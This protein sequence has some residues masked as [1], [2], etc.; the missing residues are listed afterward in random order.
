[1]EIIV[2]ILC[3]LLLCALV[4]GTLQLLSKCCK[5]Q[6]PKWLRWNK[7]RTWLTVISFVIILGRW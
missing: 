6:L 2:D 5:F 7:V 1:M 4:L 3:L